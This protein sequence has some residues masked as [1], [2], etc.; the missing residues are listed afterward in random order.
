MSITFFCV[1]IATVIYRD[2]TVCSKVIHQSDSTSLFYRNLINAS[3]S[4][5]HR[6][7]PNYEDLLPSNCWY[8][9]NFKPISANLK[10]ELS[11]WT[12]L[13]KIQELYSTNEATKIIKAVLGNNKQAYFTAHPNASNKAKQEFFC[14]PKVYLGGF[15]KC[16]TTTLYNLMVLHPSI[17]Q[18]FDKEG[19]FWREFVLAPNQTYQSLEVLLYLYHFSSASSHIKFSSQT[20]E[21]MTV[22]AS[23]STVFASAKRWV[24][25]E[26]DM[27]MIPLTLSKVL[28]NTKLVFIVRNPTDR[29]WSDYWYFCSRNRW[30]DENGRIAVP[31]SE[32][33]KS[34]EIFHNHS[35]SVIQE[36]Q[37]C[38]GHG[39]SEF[40][41]TM[42]AYSDTGEIHACKKTRLGI[43]LYYYHA[44][45]WLSVF[46]REQLM[47]VRMEDLSSDPYTVMTSVWSFM[48]LTPIPRNRFKTNVKTNANKW[49]V[50]Q[51]N[52]DNFKMWPDTRQLLDTFFAPY[53][54]LLASLLNDNRYLWK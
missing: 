18:P 22:D 41:C 28:P 1:G 3:L 16:G 36:F 24:N 50:S 32:L 52:K 54:K 47:F 44:V 38:V 51:K 37:D 29:L 34:S 40:E 15:P 26:M 19:Q 39:L 45:K 21:K 35:L 46:R 43:S 53:N 20:Y 49:I 42:R 11:S 12:K 8:I 14:M 10:R 6:L 5:W 48:D 9:G 31:D 7:I 17:E 27:C 30:I 33:K 23:A 2:L 4:A 25:V 13:Y